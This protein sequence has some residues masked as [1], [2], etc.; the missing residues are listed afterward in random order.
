MAAD[1]N[2]VNLEKTMNQNDRLNL[3]FLRNLSPAGLAEWY[4]Q[5]SEDDIAYA[6]EL[7]DAWEAEL[8]AEEFKDRGFTIVNIPTVLQ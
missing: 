1:F 6:Q 3:Q 8:L 4:A 5:S 2:L 7:L